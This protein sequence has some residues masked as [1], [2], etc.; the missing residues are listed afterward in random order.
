[1]P[2]WFVFIRIPK[3]E[4][5]RPQWLTFIRNCG[6][7]DLN[8]KPRSIICSEHFAVDCFRSYNKTK[9]LKEYA[10]PFIA[11]DRLK[12]VWQIKILIL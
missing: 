1:M 12:S 9:L 2:V 6:K 8:I 7:D 11:I 5:Y 3:N 4:E 10:V